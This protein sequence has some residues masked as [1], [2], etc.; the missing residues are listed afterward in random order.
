MKVKTF[1]IR[2]HF[3]ESG[4]V[5]P[6][7]SIDFHP[8]YTELMASAGADGCI[9][10]ICVNM[11]LYDSFGKCQWMVMLSIFLALMTLMHTISQSM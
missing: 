4:G 11:F 1:E 2:W 10:V 3:D 8:T 7:F 6:I 9:R 5:K